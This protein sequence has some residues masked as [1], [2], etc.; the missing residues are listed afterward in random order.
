MTTMIYTYFR[1]IKL[2]LFPS[3]IENHLRDTMPEAIRIPR[4]DE[5]RFEALRRLQRNRL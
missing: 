2:L 1:L 5:E 3:I 4:H